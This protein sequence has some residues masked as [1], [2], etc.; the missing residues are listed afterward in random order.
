MKS[1]SLTSRF[2]A[3]FEPLVLPPSGPDGMI[4]AGPPSLLPVL[5]PPTLCEAGPCRNYHRVA[6]VM[7]AEDGGTPGATHR[8]V[9]RACYPAPGIE[10]EIGET[11][12]L[13]CSRWEPDNE[14]ARLDSI[15]MSFLK[16][17]DGQAHTTKVLAFEQAEAALANDDDDD[18]IDMAEVLP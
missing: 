8:Q 10:L 16:S 7:D 4:P 9:T 3:G 14:Q 2:L 15:R 6:S 17:V 5:Q 12:V 13:Q 1:S 18:Q 11:P